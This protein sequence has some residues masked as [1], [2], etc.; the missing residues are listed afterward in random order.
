MS[1]LADYYKD[2]LN[3]EGLPF[4]PLVEVWPTDLIEEIKTDFV[5]AVEASNLK[6]VPCAI[7][8]LSSNQSIGNQVEVFTIRQLESHTSAFTIT[9]CPGAGYPD[10][11][12]LRRACSK[13]IAFEFKATSDWNPSSTNRCVLTSSS[14]KIR[15]CFMPP[16]Y[17]LVC[18]V[19]YRISSGAVEIH[20][21]RLDFLEPHTPVN[22]R[23][24]ASVNHK[25][26]ATGS[27]SSIVL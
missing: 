7:R 9:R 21:I 12:L 4:Q 18:T 14:I 13:K 26:L 25:I 19:H 5:A 23:L 3:W 20:A 15:K 24:E 6:H 1:N 17:H 16:I 10:W 8:D 2:L 27:H 22:V 11:T